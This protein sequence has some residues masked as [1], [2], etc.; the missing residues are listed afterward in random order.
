M[1]KL[2][3]NNAVKA[4]ISDVSIVD[5]LDEFVG[6]LKLDNVPTEVVDEAKRCILDTASII[7]VG[8][9]SSVK[10]PAYGKPKKFMPRT[11]SCNR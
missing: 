8:Q 5:E 3:T 4:H 2:L 6:K 1:T 10:K 11:R 7:I 9:Q